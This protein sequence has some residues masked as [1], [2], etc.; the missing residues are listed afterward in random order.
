[1]VTN[2][3]R[4]RSHTSTRPEPS[5]PLAKKRKLY[6]PPRRRS[7]STSP[8]QRARRRG[9]VSANQARAQEPPGDASRRGR[10]PF[11]DE[12]SYALVAEAGLA[13]TPLKLSGAGSFVRPAAR[14]RLAR[15]F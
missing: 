5:D 15:E 1:M 14:V 2:S 4:G 11:G 12:P 7:P 6:S 13:K 8:I 10:S 9:S 3:R